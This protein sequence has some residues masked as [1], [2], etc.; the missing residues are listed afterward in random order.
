VLS[1]LNQL[2]DGAKPTHPGDLLN[3]QVTGLADAGAV[4]APSRVT[5]NV[6]GMDIPVVQIAPIGSGHQVQFFLPQNVTLGAQVPLTI[7]IDGR[8]SAPALL[9]I[10]ST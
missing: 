4:L 5:V 8:V 3:M 7:S 2:V 6:G 9:T 1:N 10:R